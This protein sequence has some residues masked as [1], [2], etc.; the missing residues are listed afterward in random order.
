ML[1]EKVQI[2][3]HNLLFNVSYVSLLCHEN[4]SM[5]C[6]SMRYPTVSMSVLSF[7]SH[8]R[9]L[10]ALKNS[11]QCTIVIDLSFCTCWNISRGIVPLASFYFLMV[12]NVYNLWYQPM[13]A[14]FSQFKSPSELP[15]LSHKAWLNHLLKGL[16]CSSLFVTERIS[17]Y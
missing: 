12:L 3:R 13:K 5:V 2:L 4:Y 8:L 16:Y 15:G 7:S 10:L 6:S 14:F 11:F 9:V 1:F 17:W